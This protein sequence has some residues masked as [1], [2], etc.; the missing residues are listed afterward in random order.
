[1][2]HINQG[3]G[4]GESIDLLTKFHNISNKLKKYK[5]SLIIFN[6]NHYMIRNLVHYRNHFTLIPLKTTNA[7][8]PLYVDLLDVF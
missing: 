6:L 5:D 7:L 3:R 4:L 2:A 1:M 8:M